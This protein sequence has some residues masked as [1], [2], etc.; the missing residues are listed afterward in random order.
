MKL[1]RTFVN[2]VY[3]AGATSRDQVIEVGDTVNL[4]LHD[5]SVVQE[6]VVE[7]GKD[8][9][10]I[11]WDH[12]VNGTH[13]NM[14]RA[15]TRDHQVPCPEPTQVCSY[16]VC[17]AI[18]MVANIQQGDN[19]DPIDVGINPLDE[20]FAPQLQ[21]LIQAWLDAN[22]GGTAEVEV[23]DGEACIRIIDSPTRFTYL[24]WVENG[25]VRQLEF[26]Q[27]NCHI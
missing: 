18:P 8:G 20:T 24:L 21:T 3:R 9:K 1:G 6:T 14:V 4:V 2:T 13:S 5:G 16:E 12:S 27:Y 23:T 7:V 19:N 26:Y 11:C 15:V 10:E 17:G 22:G 25:N